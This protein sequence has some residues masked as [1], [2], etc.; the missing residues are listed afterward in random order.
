[1]TSSCN[2]KLEHL[3]KRSEFVAMGGGQKVHTS[4]IVLQMRKRDGDAN[5]CMRAGFTVTRKVGNAIVRNRIK[6]RL[7]AV[8]QISL[9]SNGNSGHDYVLIGKRA[10]LNA[11][12]GSLV[13]EMR[14]ALKR[15]HHNPAAIS[16]N[17]PY[18]QEI[19]NGQ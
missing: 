11:K 15:L 3:R 6:R 18:R 7:R 4:S 19:K 17:T 14:K 12:F 9:S 1:M 10:A 5:E 2:T 16:E 13:N 8:A